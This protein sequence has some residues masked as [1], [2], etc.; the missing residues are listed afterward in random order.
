[1]NIPWGAFLQITCFTCIRVKYHRFSIALSL[2]P[3]VKFHN[4]RCLVGVGHK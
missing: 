4:F 1:M 2:Q 3:R